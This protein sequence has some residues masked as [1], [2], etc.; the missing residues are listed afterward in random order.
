MANLKKCPFCKG[1][2][3]LIK[4]PLW[5]GS[6]GYHG[7]YEFYVKCNNENCLVKPKARAYHTIYEKNEQV[8]IDKAI[9]AWNNREAK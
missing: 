1:D 8:Q 2:V 5:N 3:L 9:D 4:D 7:C 6:H